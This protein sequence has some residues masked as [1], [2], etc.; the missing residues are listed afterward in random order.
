M[1]LLEHSCDISLVAKNPF[2]SCLVL[3]GATGYPDWC[4]DENA[5]RLPSS[6]LTL[7]QCH[8]VL[9]YLVALSG[10]LQ[11]WNVS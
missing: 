11:E 8:L 3:H 4:E 6:L 2:G 10:L 7:C 1:H 9:P 5:A